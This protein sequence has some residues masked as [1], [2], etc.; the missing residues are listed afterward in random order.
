MTA[1]DGLSALEILKTYTPDVIFVDLVM[2]NIDGKRLCKIIRGKKELKDVYLIILSA[3]A[4][5]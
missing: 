2:P 3:V 4:A 1:E 5:E